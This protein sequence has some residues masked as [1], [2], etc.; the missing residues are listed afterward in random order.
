MATESSRMTG[1]D[2]FVDMMR[3]WRLRTLVWLLAEVGNVAAM[4][5]VESSRYLLGEEVV[6]ALCQ[7]IGMMSTNSYVDMSPFSSSNFFRY[8]K[9]AEVPHWHCT[10]EE[11]LQDRA[12]ATWAVTPTVMKMNYCQLG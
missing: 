5:V 4:V 8:K 10:L 1:G 12:S 11:S 2:V 3:R 7:K 6:G 9:R